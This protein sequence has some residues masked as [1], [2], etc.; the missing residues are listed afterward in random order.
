MTLAIVSPHRQLHGF[1]ILELVVTLLII[2]IVA[3]P[4]LPK[5][6][7]RQPY[8]ERLFFDDTLNALRYAQ[9]L[10]VVSG[11]KVQVVINADSYILR[12]PADSTQCLAAS[13][14]FSLSVAHPGSGI[15]SY[16][17]SESGI[18]LTASVANVVF[19]ALGRASSDAVLTIGG[20]RTINIVAET[21]FVY[22]STP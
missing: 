7:Q 20:T 11:C 15:A 13:P 5:F 18:T 21:G 14:A 2:G 10:A 19:D 9:K 17:G 1:T 3:L 16:S 12:Q 4:A 6:F 22:D 8:Q